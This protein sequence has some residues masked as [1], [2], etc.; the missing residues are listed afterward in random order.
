MKKIFSLLG[1]ILLFS[2][3]N[4]TTYYVDASKPDDN[5][6]G[7]SWAT[8]KRTIT[9]AQTFAGS[10]DNIFVKAGD[11]YI[12]SSSKGVYGFTTKAD[13]NYYGSFA[14]TESTQSQRALSDLDGNGIVESWELTNPTT[15]NLT[16]TNNAGG[17]YITGNT[18]LFKKFDGFTI[19]GSHDFGTLTSAT[20]ATQAIFINQYSLFQ[21]NTITG[22]TVSG[23]VNFAGAYL[24]GSVL[25]INGST[26]NVTPQSAGPATVNS[27]LFENNT[28]SVTGG[29]AQTD[30]EISS[31][32]RVEG[33]SSAGRNLFANCVLRK[34]QVTVDFSGASLI[35]GANYNTRAFLVSLQLPYSSGG[36]TVWNAFKNNMIY[37]NEAAYVPFTTI[38]SYM[39]VA[40]AALVYSY[41]STSNVTDSITNNTLANN[42]MTRIGYAMSV[43]ANSAVQKP[44]HKVFNNVL[45]NNMSY[46]SSQ[47]KVLY[48]NLYAQIS[49]DA[50]GTLGFVVANN[51]CTYDCPKATPLYVIDNIADLSG[52]N[53]MDGSKGAWFTSPSKNFGFTLLS[54]V[55]LTS[56]QTANWKIGANSYLI[57]KGHSLL[58]GAIDKAGILFASTPS[59]GAYEFNSNTAV[60]K[61]TFDNNL[62]SVQG[63][64][65][66]FKQ[67]GSVQIYSISGKLVKHVSVVDGTITLNN[68]G[69]YILK[70]NTPDG[71]KVQKVLIRN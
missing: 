56:V 27:C 9:A 43:G 53:N 35:T 3:L 30:V 66:S 24:S 2:G 34:N 44:F 14:G 10:G 51:I 26:S 5:G 71:I 11:Y 62:V 25:K 31:F 58:S 6:N 20:C 50:S 61:V 32:I 12:D 45:Y 40:N 63:N 38:A 41:N 29:S 1:L 4:A 22:L 64:E 16:L 33:G 59:V 17:I 7:T 39:D 54:P 13:V 18:A 52:T 8:A 42:Y 36:V 46:I 69:V 23:T 47:S 49:T 57:G 19:T 60:E 21:N 48:R 37:N 15:L 70:Q 28:V 55:E 65:L 67:T 68:A